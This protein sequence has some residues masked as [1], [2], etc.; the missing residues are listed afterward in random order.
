MSENPHDVEAAQAQVA[1]ARA[2]LFGTLGAVQER[3][4][5]TNLAQ[6]AVES[7]AQSVASAARKGAETVRSRP[8]AAAAIAGTVGLVFARG[9]IA[10][11]LRR[12]NP[13]ATAPKPKGLDKEPKS[14]KPAKKG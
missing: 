5:P 11:A 9:W 10:D 4:S 7:A 8:F 14:A 12:R 13:H 6:D 1:A 3:L 2:K